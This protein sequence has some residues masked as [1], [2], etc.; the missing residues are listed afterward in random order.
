MSQ[1]FYAASGTE[2]SL[3]IYFIVLFLRQNTLK[4]ITPLVKDM[5]QQYPSLLAVIERY[6]HTYGMYVLYTHNER[7]KKV[8][9][10]KTENNP[11]PPLTS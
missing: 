7:Q 9:F 6:I 10:E 2:F 4:L 11:V 3:N 5:P 1:F 8:F